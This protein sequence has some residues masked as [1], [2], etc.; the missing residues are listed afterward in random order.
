MNDTSSHPYSKKVTVP[1]SLSNPAGEHNG[2]R[3]DLSKEGEPLPLEI[4]SMDWQSTGA[5]EALPAL[6]LPRQPQPT[7]HEEGGKFNRIKKGLQQVES[8]KRHLRRPL[9]PKER[10][11][12]AFKR[13]RVC[14][15]CRSRKIKV[16]AN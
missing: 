2:I 8:R 16:G 1:S 13:G 6:D 11:Q 4:S 9:S 10:A 7:T 15:E 12:V 14:L 3:A 5:P